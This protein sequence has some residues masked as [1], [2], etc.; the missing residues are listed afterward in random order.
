MYE[1]ILSIEDLLELQR[2]TE[3]PPVVIDC[4]FSLADP[5]WGRKEYEKGHIPGAQYAHLNDD[6]SGRVVPG[7]TGRHPLPEAERFLAWV[8]NAG[9]G[10]QT[11][12]VVYDQGSGG[13]AARL[14]WLPRWIGHDA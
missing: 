2:S 11:Q 9:I 5:Q 8:E 10:D 13:Y 14:W 6:L 1:T 7:I 4:R 12:V 3:R